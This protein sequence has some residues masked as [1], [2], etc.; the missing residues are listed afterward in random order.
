MQIIENLLMDEELERTIDRVAALKRSVDFWDRLFFRRV[1]KDYRKLRSRINNLNILIS[2]FN[3][4]GQN[5]GYDSEGE[6]YTRIRE[7]KRG[8][9]EQAR[10]IC[11]EI[12]KGII[13]NGMEKRYGASFIDKVRRYEDDAD[14]FHVYLEQEA[15]GKNMPVSGMVRVERLR[16]ERGY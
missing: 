3:F 8:I 15:S 13:D 9:F 4:E 16:N 10:E 2:R 6:I 12:R 11:I 5:Q 7:N 14:Y 1:I